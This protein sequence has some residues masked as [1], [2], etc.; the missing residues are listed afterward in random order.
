MAQISHCPPTSPKMFFRRLKAFFLHAFSSA[1][2]LFF[3]NLKF[4]HFLQKNF[5]LG[6]KKTILR[7][8]I[9]FYSRTKLPPSKSLEK[10][11]VFSTE[12]ELFL[13]QMAFTNSYY[14]WWSSCSITNKFHSKTNPK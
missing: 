11:H 5:N 9:I 1:N 7:K 4:F 12:C 3:P 8:N 10:N 6:G 14:K 13:L 2:S